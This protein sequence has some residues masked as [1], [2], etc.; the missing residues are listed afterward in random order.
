[1]CTDGFP[2]S[3]HDRAVRILFPGILLH[4]SC[5]VTVRN[6]TDILAVMFFRI[7]KLKAI[8]NFSGIFFS[9]LS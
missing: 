6:K 9:N 3:V 1:M 2:C 8:S 4:K 7:A 5:I